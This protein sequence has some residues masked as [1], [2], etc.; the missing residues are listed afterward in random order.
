[1]DLHALRARFAQSPIWP[2]AKNIYINKNIIYSIIVP[3]V[4]KGCLFKRILK[5]I[6]KLLLIN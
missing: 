2:P 6:R 5:L 3:L 1:M 4:P